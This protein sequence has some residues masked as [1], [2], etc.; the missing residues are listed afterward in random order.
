M[1]ATI[2]I[3][4]ASGAI[5]IQV[6]ALRSG[7]DLAVVI[8]GGDR[9]HIGA[10]AL[11]QPRPSL[12][13]NGDISASTSVLTLLGHKE[14]EIARASAHRIASVLNTTVTVACGIHIDNIN[15]NGL[16]QVRELIDDATGELIAT[17]EKD[18]S[19]QGCKTSKKDT[20]HCRLCDESNH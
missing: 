6:R 17:L 1:S 13:N 16:R 12:K 5:T 9:A 14:D 8:N 15:E 20:C 19:K 4:R 2:E 7:S 11:S 3:S 18:K 10:V